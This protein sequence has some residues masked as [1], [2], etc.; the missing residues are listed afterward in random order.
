[1]QLYWATWYAFKNNNYGV[2]I[3]ATLAEMRAKLEALE[4]NNKNK[5]TTGS[6]LV[7][8]F[9]EIPEDSTV[10]IR[11]LP[12]ADPD[13]TFFWKEIQMI[14]LEFPGVKGGD[15]N[16]RVYIKVP[17]VEMWGDTCPVHAEL[18]PMFKDSSLEEIA[19]KYWKKRSYIFQGLVMD[20][21]LNEDEVPANPIRR[22]NLGKQ[23]YNIVKNALM[24]P[25]MEHL[26]TDYLN[27][28]NFRI[29]R[30]KKGQYNDYNTS[31]WSRKE[32]A[33]T[34][35]QLTAV[36][37]N[38]LVTLTDWMPKKPTAEGVQAI[39]EMFEAS[40]EGELYDPDRWAAYYRPWGLEYDGA[41]KQQT[42]ESTAAPKSTVSPN[43]DRVANLSP[44][45]EETVEEAVESPNVSTASS[46]TAQ[47]I[48]AKIRNRDNA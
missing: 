38:G 23:L 36:D 48:L 9:W 43:V 16:K 39:F 33:L 30:T 27:G 25:D 5:R 10:Q 11:F 13:N 17:C 3:M 14:N 42:T 40:L 41:G 45:R 19:R 46:Q 2:I 34:E 35:E 31:S 32:S 8:P 44:T 20:S 26:P 28:I 22:I 18:R 1:M 12:D 6:S 7:Y 21:P 15:E 47:D 29:T 24:D 37:T 4:N